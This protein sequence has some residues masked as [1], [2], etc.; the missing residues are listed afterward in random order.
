MG[1]SIAQRCRQK[2]ATAPQAQRAGRVSRFK[3]KFKGFGV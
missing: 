3:D 2:S 1:S